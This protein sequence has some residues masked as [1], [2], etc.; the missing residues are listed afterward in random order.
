[1]TN[2][3]ALAVAESMGAVADALRK[4]YA[5]F[6]ELSERVARQY[7]PLMAV[8]ERMERELAR[9]N[10]ASAKVAEFAAVHKY[11]EQL[12]AA[13]KWAATYVEPAWSAPITV[14]E[15]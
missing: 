7:A 9:V 6:I 13:S 12:D 2:I 15:P 14:R 1:M 3:A 4:K 11:V 5:P 8:G 10:A